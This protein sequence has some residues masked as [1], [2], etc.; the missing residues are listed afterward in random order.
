MKHFF[1]KALFVLM[2]LLPYTMFSQEGCRVGGEKEFVDLLRRDFDKIRRMEGDFVRAS[3]AKSTTLTNLPVQFHL[4]RSSTGQTTFAESNLDRSITILNQYFANAGLSF[5]QCSRVKY[6]DDN[7][8]QDFYVSKQSTLLARSFVKN[9]INIYCVPSIE[10]GMVG[11]YTYLPGPFSPDLIVMDD[12]L[13]TSTTLTH[14]MGHYFGLLH[15]HGSSN[16]GSSANA[17]DELVDGSN[18]QTAGDYVCDTPADPGLL[19]A[20]CAAYQVDA[21]CNYIGTARDARGMA[22]TP[23]VNNIMSYSRSSCR[24]RLSPGQYSRINASYKTYRTYLTCSDTTKIPESAYLSMESPIFLQPNPVKANTA[25]TLSAQLKNT[26]KAGFKGRIRMVLFNRLEQQIAIIGTTTISD[27]LRVGATTSL[28]PFSNPSLLLAP[29][30][31]KAGVF[32]QTDTTQPFSAVGSEKY[33][34]LISFT[35]EGAPPGCDAPQNLKSTEAGVSHVAFSW[36]PSPVAGASYRISYREKDKTSWVEISSWSPTRVII[37]NRKPCTSY[38]FRAKTVCS[39]GESEWSPIATATTVGCGDAYCASYGSSM[40]TFIEEVSIG[41][42]SNKSGNNYGFGNYTQLRREVRAGN[43]ASLL[44]VPGMASGESLRVVFWRAWAD[45][46][47]DGDFEDAGELVFQ[48]SDQNNRSLNGSIPIPASATSGDVRLRISVDSR[49]FPTPCS[50]N[51]FREV[52]DYTLVVA[53]SAASLRINTTALDFTNNESTQQVTLESSMAWT[54]T[55]SASWMRVLPGSGNGGT[56]QVAITCTANSTLA[57]REGTV[58]FVSGNLQ[59]TLSVRQ[60]GAL[61]TASALSFPSAGGQQSILINADAAC[62]FTKIPSWITTTLA[63]PVQGQSGAQLLLTCAPNPR[64]SARTDT[65]RMA[66]PNGSTASVLIQQGANNGPV[67]WTTSPSPRRHLVVLPIELTGNLNGQNLS[68]GDYIGI[69]YTDNSQERC[70]GYALWTGQAGLMTING[71]NPLTPQKDGMADGEVFKV[72]VWKLSNQ[73][74]Y[75]VNAKFTAPVANGLPSHSNA[76]ANNGASRLE[77]VSTNAGFSFQLTLNAGFNLISFPVTPES[78]SPFD[79]FSSAGTA[80]RELQDANGAKTY[81]ATRRNEIGP[82]NPKQGYIAFMDRATTVEIRGEKILPSGNP[83]PLQAGWHI[84]PFWA[85]T[86]KPVAEAV[87]SL[88]GALQIIKDVDGKPYL[89]GYGIN[90]IGNLQP[91]RGY[92]AYLSRPDTLIFTDAYMDAPK[93]GLVDVQEPQA[94]RT[95]RFSLSYVQNLQV[96]AT[97]VITANGMESILETGDEIGVFSASGK[98][99][100]AAVY[101]GKNLAIPVW[102]MPQGGAYTFKIYKHATGETVTMAPVFKAGTDRTFVDKGLTVL[103]GFEYGSDRPAPALAKGEWSIFPNPVQGGILTLDRTSAEPAVAF[104]IH[105]QGGI[106]KQWPINGEGRQDLQLPSLAPG[107]YYLQVNDKAGARRKP[108][109]IQY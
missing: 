5:Y 48:G 74:E 55:P 21:S 43:T 53:A 109:I 64:E 80:I 15:S 18:C 100:G 28:L 63:N 60:R 67:T 31:Y 23:D 92:W 101:R 86:P 70:A 98:L 59:Q 3:D 45:F 56:A 16:C 103:L 93:N 62:N 89:P 24:T 69:F 108:V 65:L 77:N 94:L 40:R 82:L 88:N 2:L 22:F 84:I 58:S 7:N 72:R 66:W 42:V 107:M 78:L 44:L 11:G 9:V 12:G 61:T 6:I 76:F 46:N 68:S 49:E 81:F 20:G 50:V 96:N 34:S 75:R 97:I 4:V 99:S 33:N 17:T 90:N 10:G 8:L 87:V 71:D 38:E 47:R 57:Q 32:F 54:A 83:I 13:L 35:V 19:G 14:E 27:S 29:D 95:N 91:G 85:L 102:D 39:T 26:G 106:I 36:D 30:T 79:V 51:D 105:P 37:L 1:P 104:L 73:Q 25:F 41:G 52:E